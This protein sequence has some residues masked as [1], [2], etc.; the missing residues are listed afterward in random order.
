MNVIIVLVTVALAVTGCGGVTDV[1]SL[2][3]LTVRIEEGV[4][5]RH[6]NK[7]LSNLQVSYILSYILPP[8]CNLQSFP[9]IPDCKMS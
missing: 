6:C 7:T 9:L 1:E 2:K 5:S 8:R 3:K 4:S